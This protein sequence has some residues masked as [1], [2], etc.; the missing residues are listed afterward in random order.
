VRLR[1]SGHVGE[2]CTNSS[3]CTLFDKTGLVLPAIGAAVVVVAIVVVVV[4]VVRVGACSW[5]VF[6]FDFVCREGDDGRA[7]GLD[8]DTMC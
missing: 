3:N 5:C 7:D 8:P 1:G 2:R 6:A 4:V